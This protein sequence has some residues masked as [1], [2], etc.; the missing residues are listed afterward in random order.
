M[1]HKNREYFTIPNI[2]TL[3][4]VFLIP[5]F[6]FYAYKGLTSDFPYIFIATDIALFTF[7]II[8]ITDCLDGWIA[9]LTNS[10]SILGS[11][12]DVW[13]DF[14]FVLCSFLMLNFLN[15]IPSWL[16]ALAIYKF[17]EFLIL[18]EVIKKHSAEYNINSDRVLY[19]D[20]PGRIASALFYLLPSLILIL[21]L[22]CIDLVLLNLVCYGLLLFTLFSS[23]LK[24]MNIREIINTNNYRVSS[25][26]IE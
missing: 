22:L 12:L 14:L 7:I 18:S 26:M 6:L 16:T 13:S 19:Y 5:V 2:I 20:V 11:Y 9:R 10:T 15:I 21:N 8:R 24:Y 23:F 17:F 4:R 3:I 1:T 25:K